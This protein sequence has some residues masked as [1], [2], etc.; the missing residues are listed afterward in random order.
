MNAGFAASD[1]RG[2]THARANLVAVIVTVVAVTATLP[3]QR[4]F[5]SRWRYPAGH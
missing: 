1:F 4:T 3:F 2:I 5:D